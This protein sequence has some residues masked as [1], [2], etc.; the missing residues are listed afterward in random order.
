MQYRVNRNCADRFLNAKRQPLAANWAE[1]Y[2]SWINDRI[3]Y[4]NAGISKSSHQRCCSRSNRS[5][6]TKFPKIQKGAVEAWR[7]REHMGPLA[8]IISQCLACGPISAG[9]D[10]VAVSIS[11]NSRSR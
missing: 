1:S 7:Y 5:R 6:T 4:M 3:N 9:C 11:S 2:E 8:R 10:R